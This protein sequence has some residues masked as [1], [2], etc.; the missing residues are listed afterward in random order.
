MKFIIYEYIIM[1]KKR[2]RLV[3]S[4]NKGLSKTQVKTVR[5]I[6]MKAARSLPETK[7]AVFLDENIQLV[8]NKVLYLGKW[9]NTAQG[10]QDPNDPL[11]Q[12]GRLLRIGDELLLR[13]INIR[14]YYD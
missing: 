3:K 5:K 6:A 2:L 1:P 4:L 12:T 13:N 14:F 10:V 7:N 9:L 11:T 8:H